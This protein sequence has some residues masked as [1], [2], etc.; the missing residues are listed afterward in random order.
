MNSQSKYSWMDRFLH[1]L[2]LGN[3]SI[4][5]VSFDIDQRAIKEPNGQT[6]D[7]HVFVSG[8]A[9]S[10]TTILMRRLYA[11]GQFCSL[12]YRDM[13]FI[14]APNSFQFL[15][16]DSGK[17]ASP[18][19]RAHGD[20]ILVNMDSPESLDEVFWRIF[21]G[22]TYIGDTTLLRHIPERELLK[23]FS[24]YLK[25]ILY[26]DVSQ[27]GRYL[28][29]NNNN[30]LRLPELAAHFPNSQILVPF[31]SPEAHASSLLRQHQNFTRSQREDPFIQNYM[32]WLVHHEFGLDHRPFNFA[33]DESGDDATIDPFSVDYWIQQWTGTYRWLE[34]IAP[35]NATF[36]CYE[37]LCRNPEVWTS[38]ASLCDVHPSID[39]EK[40]FDE[41]AEARGNLDAL[42][43]YRRLRERSQ[44]KLSFA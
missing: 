44:S 16:K 43:I 25:A 23:K 32:T 27:R 37:D 39:G 33:C 7:Q 28:S 35:P 13:P 6:D 21:D 29:K 22:G 41:V 2:A 17:A 5:E 15:K 40:L 11:T 10:G 4:A 14:L 42:E 26:A 24:D 36:V 1:R 12:T 30:L 19:V 8:L 34:E 18:T 38:I 31:R 3:R 9:R 20:G